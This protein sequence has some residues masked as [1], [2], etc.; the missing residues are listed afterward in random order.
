MVPL[1]YFMSLPND[2]AKVQT[3]ITVKLVRT[4]IVCA[5]SCFFFLIT[6]IVLLILL[7]L[8][9]ALSSSLVLA[10]SLFLS[11]TFLD[12]HNV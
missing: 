11:Q 8:V 5:S 2:I 6:I 10:L 3:A 9:L 4:A 1:I 7:S 12:Q